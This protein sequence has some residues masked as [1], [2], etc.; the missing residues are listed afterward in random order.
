MAGAINQATGGVKTHFD[1]QLKSQ[2]LAADSHSQE[3]EKLKAKKTIFRFEGNEKQ[4]TFNNNT[5]E[6]LDQSVKLIE[7]NKASVA[8]PILEKVLK[9]V[10]LHEEQIDK[11]SGQV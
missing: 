3:L 9:E 10:K 5:I 1:G 7:T 6:P 8:K 2:K 4:V 11:I